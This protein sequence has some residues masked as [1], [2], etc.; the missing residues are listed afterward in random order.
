MDYLED[1]EGAWNDASNARSGIAPNFIHSLDAAHLMKV[2]NSC[3]DRGIDSLAVIH[4]SFGTHAAR[5]DELAWILR[6][7]F[8]DLYQCN[9]LTA[10]RD[11]VRDQLEDDPDIAEQI[12]ALP[13]QGDLDLEAIRQ[14]RYMFA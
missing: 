4:D 11:A 5:T 13:D 2:A 6:E 1:T 7:T 14:A 3:A 12:P 9:P 8:I 10:F